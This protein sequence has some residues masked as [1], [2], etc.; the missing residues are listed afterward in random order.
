MKLKQIFS[1]LSFLGYKLVVIDKKRAMRSF[2]FGL[3]GL[4]VLFLANAIWPIIS[5]EVFTASSFK[6]TDLISPIIDSGRVLGAT[7]QGRQIDST[8][9]NSWFVGNAGLTAVNSKVRYYNISVPKLG[10]KSAVVEIGG[11]NLKQNLV[12]YKDTA[13]PGQNGN[14]VIFGHSALPQFYNTSNYLTIF[15]KLPTLK[16]G[17]EMLVDYDG[18]RYRYKVEEMYE[19]EATDIQVLAQRFDDSYLTLIT[20]VPPGTLLRRL[21]VKARLTSS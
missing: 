2:S 4:G 13:L 15:S 18:I 11:E 17:D 5:Y 9:A 1:P 10:I 20:C 7:I 19:V 3:V 21:V 14:S 12:Q 6:R 8:N 16:K